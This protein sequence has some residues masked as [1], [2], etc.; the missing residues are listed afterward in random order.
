MIGSSGTAKGADVG[1]RVA[2][3]CV[4]VEATRVGR[5]SGKNSAVGVGEA[6]REGGAV[7][8]GLDVRIG[9][10]TRVGPAVG[11]GANAGV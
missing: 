3:D 6:G 1:V 4:G 10:T 2:W 9:P 5:G 11:S 7:A 8:F